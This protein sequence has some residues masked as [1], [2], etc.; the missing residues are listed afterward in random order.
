MLMDSV[1]LH[2]LETGEPREKLG[3]AGDII[4]SMACSRDESKVLAICK[5][6][7]VR[8]WDA[9]SGAALAHLGGGGS[10]VMQAAFS[11]DGRLIASI[12]RDATVR[13]WELESQGQVAQWMVP[14]PGIS[15]F[16]PTSSPGQSKSTKYNISGF[17]FAPHGRAIITCSSLALKT[18]EYLYRF[19]S[20]DTGECQRELRGVTSLEIL[21][22]DATWW[23]VS[24][25]R[26]TVILEAA[27]GQPV[28]SLPVPLRGLIAHP[29]GRTWVGR[30]GSNALYHVRLETS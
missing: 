12:S 2:D 17:A 8:V 10:S 23:P 15:S 4:R 14:D 19:W 5:D 20:I 21:S 28:A 6:E 1:W 9:I 7:S 24:S 18:G 30:R 3:V 25:D 11:P 13:I 29:D 22:S 16:G 27:T 26:E